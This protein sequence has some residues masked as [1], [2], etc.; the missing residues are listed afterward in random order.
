MYVILLF[1]CTIDGLTELKSM[2]FHH[3][4]YLEDEAIMQLV[5]VK[6]CLEHLEIGSCGDISNKGL[7]SLTELK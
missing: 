2:R 4:A 3:C 5:L 1:M 7:S 6:D